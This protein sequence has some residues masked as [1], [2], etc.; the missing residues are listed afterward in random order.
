[1]GQVDSLRRTVFSDSRRILKLL[2]KVHIDTQLR[3]NN[4]MKI[5]VAR[6]IKLPNIL[7]PLGVLPTTI[8]VQT[9]ASL[10]GFGFLINQRSYHGTFDPS[11][12]TYSINVLELMAT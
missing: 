7:V 5:A 10:K 8:M 6:W 11:M 9:D 4:E 12:E 1:M 3:V 2:R